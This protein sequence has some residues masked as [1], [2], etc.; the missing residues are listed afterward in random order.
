MYEFIFFCVKDK[1]NYIF[2]FEVILVEVK[3]GVKR[4]LI[5]YRKNL[6]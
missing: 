3:I 2:N 5:D 1:N 4:G 6:F